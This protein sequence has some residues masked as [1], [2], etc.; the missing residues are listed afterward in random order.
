MTRT[1]DAGRCT[2]SEVG[3][4]GCQCEYRIM[5][6]VC[7]IM[8]FWCPV[9]LVSTATNVNF[10]PTAVASGLSDDNSDG[11]INNSVK[12]IVPVLIGSLVAIVSVVVVRHQFTQITQPNSD[13]QYNR[14][15]FGIV[16]VFAGVR[17][18]RLERSGGR[19]KTATG[20]WKVKDKTYQF[21]FLFRLGGKVMS[22]VVYPT[23][24]ILRN[25]FV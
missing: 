14:V 13:R 1:R 2:R 8:G 15:L 4:L 7:L 12:I 21:K 22:S 20:H 5:W 10:A 6:R 24:S 25:G 19:S 9:P 11:S 23:K 16:G 18:N 3:P 17:L